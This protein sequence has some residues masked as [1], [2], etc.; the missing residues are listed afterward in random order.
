MQPADMKIRISIILMSDMRKLKSFFRKTNLIF[1]EFREVFLK[2]FPLIL[3]LLTNII[4]LKAKTIFS[5]INIL[6]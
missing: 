5:Y 6:P 4:E 2:L 1:K 3:L